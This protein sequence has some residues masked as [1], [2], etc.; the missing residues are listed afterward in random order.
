MT[1]MLYIYYMYIKY[2]CN[3]CISPLCV[4]LIKRSA[5]LLL[6]DNLIILSICSSPFP[7]P[8]FA[9]LIRFVTFDH[10]NQ[11]Y[12]IADNLHQCFDMTSNGNIIF[13]QFFFDTIFTH[14]DRFCLRLQCTDW[15]NRL[16]IFVSMLS[17]SNLPWNKLGSIAS[18][19]KHV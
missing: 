7:L 10:L 18:F 2:M 8:F 6:L 12:D 9:F 4:V 15:E 14:A 1:Y 13:H 5:S 19:L 3:C 11:C 17:Y 16:H